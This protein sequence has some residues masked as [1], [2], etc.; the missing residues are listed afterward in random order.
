MAFGV[1]AAAADG[2][3]APG[4]A[5]RTRRRDLREFARVS[6]ATGLPL[7]TGKDALAP[8]AP[9]PNAGAARGLRRAPRPRTSAPPPIRHRLYGIS[10]SRPRL[11]DTGHVAV[12][13]SVPLP[14][15]DPGRFL[16]SEPDEAL[17]ELV[18]G[19]H[20]AAFEA[21]YDR[22]H[23]GLLAFC[24]H[25]LGSR[26]EGEDALQHTFAAAYRALTGAGERPR[27]LK[28]WLYAIA[29]NRCISVLR[30]RR[31][32]EAAPA[33]DE[34]ADAPV[35]DGLADAVQ[36]RDDLRDLV[37]EIHRLPDD[38]R[39]ALVLFEL[40]DHSHAEIAAVLSIDRAKV[41]A[42]VFQAREG[43]LRAR[44]ARDTPC[45][46]IR[47]S[48]SSRTRFLGHRGVV[49]GH[50]D[51]CAACAAYD[52]EVRR[53][54]SALALALPVLPSLELKDSVLGPL[55]G[56]GAGG[57]GGGAGGA[58]GGRGGPGRGGAAAERAPAL[59]A[60]ARPAE[61]GRPDPGRPERVR[62]HPARP[63]QAP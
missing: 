3:G 12:D 33:Y 34:E 57:A 24:R 15:A 54:R 52:L 43:L 27:D 48:L 8:R 44:T 58:G 62:P 9:T 17:V 18:R 46:E 39:A 55:I 53:Q 40:G 21:I 47:R 38:Q 30:A 61:P 29:R 56:G 10:R 31:P 6:S 22:H 45:A 14:G 42:L 25:M 19:G 60:R 32:D 50:L 59:R 36:R 63:P 1:G 23:R 11:G 16:R 49:R 26:E 35:A 4:A 13:V 37:A 2:H 5:A 28:P 20:E 7:G 41:K 51:R